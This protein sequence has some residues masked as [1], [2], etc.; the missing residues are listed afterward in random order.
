LM[1][2]FTIFAGAGGSH[3]AEGAA[4]PSWRCNPA[5]QLWSARDYTGMPE[6]PTYVCCTE[7]SEATQHLVICLPHTKSK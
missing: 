4:P 6:L 3:K 5:S 1:I 7:P 2:E